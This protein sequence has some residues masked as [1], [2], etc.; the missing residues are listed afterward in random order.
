V[1]KD[2][3]VVVFYTNNLKTMPTAPM[4]SMESDEAIHAVNGTCTIRRW[5]GS[6]VMCQSMIEVLAFVGACNSF[7]IMVDRMDQIRSSCPSRH[8]ETRVSMMLV[9][10]VLDLAIKN[11]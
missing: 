11:A 3:K 4:L 9:T 6:E 1:L 5:T 7:K 2:A 10:L 8:R